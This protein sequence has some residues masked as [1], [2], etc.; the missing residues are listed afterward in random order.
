MQ[1]AQ[2]G[3]TNRETYLFSLTIL[4]NYFLQIL[5]C[6]LFTTLVFLQAKAKGTDKTNV[7][8]QRC[9]TFRNKVHNDCEYDHKSLGSSD[10]TLDQWSDRL[11]T[12]INQK[13]KGYS[14]TM[15]NM[16]QIHKGAVEIYQLFKVNYL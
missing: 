3:T 14:I 1:T 13:S 6:C 2:S 7:R 5:C 15:P 8:A 11:L 9:I 16:N 4:T 12:V 10:L